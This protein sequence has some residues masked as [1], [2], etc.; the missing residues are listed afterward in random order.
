MNVVRLKPENEDK[1][2]SAKS[3]DGRVVLNLCELCQS[4]F[5]GVRGSWHTS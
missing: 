2:K 4:M 1:S 5:Q 3:N